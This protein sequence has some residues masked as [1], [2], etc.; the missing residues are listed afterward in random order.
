MT[1]IVL[2]SLCS[3]ALVTGLFC[4]RIFK[5]IR[6]DL[7]R[8]GDYVATRHLQEEMPVT[9]WQRFNSVWSKLIE[10]KQILMQR[11]SQS[12]EVGI[13]IAISSAKVSH[14]IDELTG[15]IE[16][17]MQ[18]TENVTNATNELADNTAYIVENTQRAYTSTEKATGICDEGLEKVTQI[19]N[20][21]L[22]L[23]SSATSTT[24]SM[25]ELNEYAHDIA[26]ITDVI[27]NVSDQTNLLALNAAIEAARAGELGR[28]FA[29][30][31]DEVRELANKS[32]V[33]TLEIDEKLRHMVAVSKK[34]NEEIMAFQ[35][36]VE[37]VVGQAEQIG[38]V[39][40]GINSQA[41]ITNEQ[42]DNINRIMDQHH[43]SVNQIKVE[44][45]AIKSLFGHIV[46]DAQAVSEDAISLSNQAE[47]IHTINGDFEF[48][49][50]HDRVKNIV[51]EKSKQVGELFERSIA[52]EQITEAALFDRNYKPIAG[53]NPIKYST[54][55][56]TFTD[57]MLPA[58][59]EP[60]LEENPDFILAGAV[61]NN[62]YFPTHNKRFSQPLTGDYEKDLVGNRTKRLFNDRTGSRCGSN[63]E[64]F[65]LQTYKRD[66]GEVLHDLSAPIY[67][68]GKHWGGF[69]IAYRSD[70]PAQN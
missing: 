18:R 34:T 6:A 63:R 17:Q 19:T 11:L 9:R 32:S 43:H 4:Y 38:N 26:G 61:D 40:T 20:G 49:T 56:D 70:E 37:L 21:I 65:L 13:S 64:K 68:N 53:S 29:V 36:M 51:L 10:A 12:S 44:L 8:L 46:S 55:F 14:F 25:R 58:L 30:V 41:R 45:E 3:L 50:I 24:E 57:Q 15:K 23:K 60:V 7:D 2:L 35:D 59:Q 66:T 27:K 33:S 22:N 5:L 69:R 54:E 1:E 31:A 39:L 62:G 52:N 48:G 47:Q 16:N 28:G 67:V 42:M